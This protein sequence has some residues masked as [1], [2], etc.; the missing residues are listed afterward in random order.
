MHSVESRSRCL[1]T[2]GLHVVFL[3]RRGASLHSWLRI[4]ILGGLHHGILGAMVG[5]HRVGSLSGWRVY[6]V[7]RVCMSGFL[8]E[9]MYGHALRVLID[10]KGMKNWKKMRGSFFS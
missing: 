6:H 5:G 2:S 8:A 10:V 1:Y 3:F 7:Q 9:S 4:E